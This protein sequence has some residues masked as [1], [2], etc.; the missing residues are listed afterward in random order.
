MKSRLLT[1]LSFYL[2]FLSAAF[3]Q[4]GMI[5]IDRNTESIQRL[6]KIKILRNADFGIDVLNIHDNKWEFIRFG[7]NTGE[8]INAI[9]GIHWLYSEIQI[10][11]SLDLDKVLALNLINIGSANEIYWDDTLIGKKGKI[12]ILEEKVV[13]AEQFLKLPYNHAVPGYHRLLIKTYNDK[14]SQISMVSGI[15]IGYYASFMEYRIENQYIKTFFMAVLFA[16]ALFNL[17]LFFGFNKKV[18]YLFFGLFCF[19]NS[20]MA[21][22]FPFTILD[23]IRLTLTLENYSPNIFMYIL[24]AFSLLSYLITRFS[25]HKTQKIFTTVMLLIPLGNLLIWSNP[26]KE[27]IHYLLTIILPLLIVLY[28]L[29]RKKEG[30]FYILTGLAGFNIFL[31]LGFGYFT[32]IL[33]LVVCISILSS[34]EIAAQSRRHREAILRT[35]RL[36][37]ELLKRNIQPHFILNTLTS[38]QELVE[39]NPKKASK[40]IQSLAEEFQLFSQVSGEKL[41]PISIELKICHAHLRIMEYRKGAKFKLSVQGIKGSER[42]PPGVF[43]TLIENGTTHGYSRKKNGTFLLTKESGTR[44]TRYILFNDSDNEDIEEEIRKGTGLKYIEA[45]LEESFPG[46]WKL[47][48]RRVPAGWETVIDIQENKESK[49]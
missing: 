27:R 45:R 13:R 20:R 41:I 30:G 22:F 28:A 38:L 19:A 31:F 35:A 9:E 11:D 36:E 5:K 25:F 32:G 47:S 14:R 42:I 29:Y 26:Y 10:I 21:Y 23:N 39:Q 48:C 17:V 40:L 44:S 49:K 15:E 4:E 8:S 12:G 34:R 3:P 6:R 7:E 24:A 1:T 46:S 33:F 16:S 18:E 37:N 43:H 2:F